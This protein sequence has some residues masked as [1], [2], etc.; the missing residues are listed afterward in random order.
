MRDHGIQA[1]MNRAGTWHDNAPMLSFLATLKNELVHHHA[2]QAN[3]EGKAVVRYCVEA[4]SNRRCLR[5]SSVFF[6]AH[7]RHKPVFADSPYDAECTEERF[8]VSVVAGLVDTA[9]IRESL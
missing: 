8:G 6:F 9:I 3:N 7:E 2:Y 1:S 4:F 5:L